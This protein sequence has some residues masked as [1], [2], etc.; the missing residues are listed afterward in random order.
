MASDEG[1]RRRM[2]SSLSGMRCDKSVDCDSTT[3]RENQ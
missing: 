3:D 2:G 1:G